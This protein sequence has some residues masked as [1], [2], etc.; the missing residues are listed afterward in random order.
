MATVQLQ[1]H[2]LAFS[3]SSMVDADVVAHWSVDGVVFD[4]VQAYA[5]SYIV[6]HWSVDGAVFDGVQTYASMDFS[7][8]GWVL[9][10]DW[11]GDGVF[12]NESGIYDMSMHGGRRRYIRSDGKGFEAWT[13]GTLTLKLRNQ[14]GRYDYDNISSPIY[15]N[16]KP[17][18]A[19][20][21][22]LH[23]GGDYYRVFSGDVV[24]IRPIYERGSE[25]VM[26]EARSDA[27]RLEQDVNLGMLRDMR[28]DEIISRILDAVE[29]PG[30][31]DLGE[32]ADTLDVWW[33]GYGAEARALIESLVAAE[34]GMY[35]PRMDGVFWFRNRHTITKAVETL[36][37]SDIKQGV[38]RS[39]P[40]DD[41]RNKISINVYAMEQLMS[42][43]V[44]WS[45]SGQLSIPPLG[46]RELRVRLKS[47]ELPV[48]AESLLT[49]V[50]N[51]D[52]VA[53]M[54][55]DGNG[56]DMTA[57]VIVA[58]NVAGGEA[59]IMITNNST[60]TVYMTTLQLRCD[61]AYTYEST[62]EISAE[63][64][65]AS[66]KLTL[67]NLWVTD[68]N[69]AHDMACALLNELEN[70]KVNITVRLRN[71][72][73]LQFGLHEMDKLDVS[74]NLSHSVISGDYK[75]IHIEHKSYDESLTI[76]DTWLTLEPSREVDPATTWIFPVRW[77]VN[78]RFGY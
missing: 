18:A 43:A 12:S 35:A 46:S 3:A 61:V 65:D 51:T 63:S 77:E 66:Q 50:A 45:Q 73:D 48:A 7:G 67:D 62:G 76:F 26:I 11:D 20:R 57:D 71:R 70:G 22:G 42:G 39:M 54:A 33:D 58:T 36:T 53:N 59:T 60:E 37:G 44:V 15:P 14:D 13:P 5:S 25:N 41:M 78:S 17:G 8:M 68:S 56:A 27:M 2:N 9:F 72:P 29:W 34:L 69:Q 47:G 16:L 64:G 75:I 30:L 40:W 32:G 49:P 23:Y 24:D 6:A 28:A 1:S 55:E 38:G 21:L 19:L 10:I 31:Q 52:Y 4:G 74:I